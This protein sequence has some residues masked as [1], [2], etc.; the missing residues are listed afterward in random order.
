MA[1]EIRFLV[2]PG[3][4]LLNLSG[5]LEAIA[6]AR[7]LYGVDY[8]TSIVSLHGGMVRSS[9]GLDISTEVMRQEP[10]DTLIVAG[11]LG[12]PAGSWKDELVSVLK[13][14]TPVARR[15]AC[16]CTGAFLLAESGILDG[17]R[18]TTHWYYAPELQSRYP[19]LDVD[20]DRIF[21]SDNGLWTSA[22]MSAGI[23]MVLNLIEEDAGKD[24]AQSVARMLVVY[25]RRPGGQ[26][27]FSSL[28][29]FDPG[30]DRI[31]EALTFARENLSSKLSVDTLAE[32]ASLSV[33]QFSRAFSAATGM[34]PAKAIERL[35]VDAARPMVEDTRKTLEEI[36]PLVGFLNAER[37]AQSFVRTIGQSPL[38]LR[39]QRRSA[40]GGR[41]VR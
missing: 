20:G 26:Y 29:D 32:A 18:A 36:A 38:E 41:S 31:R 3:F 21:T 19:M 34:S 30:S 13:R 23:D 15:T 4:V 16:V 12:V 28:L 40:V 1:R 35:R 5:P 25:Y 17:R 22:G 9:S 10:I 8:R 6:V 27:Q 37:M 39:R 14:V 11:A 33:R 24:V 7:D 2:Y